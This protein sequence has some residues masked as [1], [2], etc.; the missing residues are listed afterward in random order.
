MLGSYPHSSVRRGRPVDQHEAGVA[1]AQAQRD[2]PLLRRRGQEV[3]EAASGRDLD[4]GGFAGGNHGLDPG[5]CGGRQVLPQQRPF[6]I[7]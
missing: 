2:H 6:V 5:G 7:D 4:G 3:P 1:P